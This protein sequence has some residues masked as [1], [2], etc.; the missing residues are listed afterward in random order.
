MAELKP[1]STETCGLLEQ[2]RE[3]DRQAL[4]RLLARHRPRL[5]AFIEA[6]LDP[7]LRARLDPS[8]VVQESLLEVVQRM[9]DFLD[10]RPMPFHLWVRKTVYQRLLNARRDHRAAKRSMNREVALPGGP[11]A[12]L[13]SVRSWLPPG[14][15]ATRFWRLR[16]RPA[17]PSNPRGGLPDPPGR[18]F[19]WPS[20]PVGGST[21]DNDRDLALRHAPEE[22]VCLRIPARRTRCPSRSAR[23]AET[24][25][26]VAVRGAIVVAV[27]RTHIQRLIVEGAATQDAARRSLP[28]GT[29]VR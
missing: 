2:I 12:V 27:R 15:H 6:R 20:P 26:V 11:A 9:S 10:R 22:I 18:R 1:D 14:R 8:D 24:A 5:V 16:T 21:Q 19:L 3:G 23:H 7:Q 4:D 29:G 28:C 25:R 17:G 13:P